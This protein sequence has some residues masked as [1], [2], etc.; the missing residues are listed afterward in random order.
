MA[1]TMASQPGELR[2]LLL[3][4]SPVQAAAERL[5]GRRVLLVGTGTSWHAANIGAWFLRAAGVEAWPVQ[6]IDAALHGP[7]PGAGDGLILLSHRG[8]K[9][10]T[11]QVL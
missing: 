1:E 7:R 2:R 3:D 4:T 11:S 9:R 10:A 6:A 8:T 5:R